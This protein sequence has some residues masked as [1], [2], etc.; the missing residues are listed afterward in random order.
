MHINNTIGMYCNPKG[1]KTVNIIVK[2][3]DFGITGLIAIAILVIASIFIVC[4]VLRHP[5]DTIK[6]RFLKSCTL[7]GLADSQ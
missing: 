5:H 6:V 2:L 3:L 7:K 1:L 4:V